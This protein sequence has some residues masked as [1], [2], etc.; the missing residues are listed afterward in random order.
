[1]TPPGQFT[2]TKE[3][4][5]YQFPH[6]GES[7]ELDNQM[8]YWKLKAFLIDSPG[9]TWIEPHDA[10]EDDWAAFL[11]WTGH[12]NGEG[13]LSKCTAITKAKLENLHYKNEHSMS[14]ECCTEIMTKD[15]FQT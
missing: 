7:Y 15:M 14:F 13:E 5:M 2:T 12:Y 6:Q 4:R 8:V 9:W 3:Q 11:A 1:M 10:S